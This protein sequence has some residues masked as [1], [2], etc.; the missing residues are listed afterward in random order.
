MPQ[1]GFAGIFIILGLV[2]VVLVAV[3][4]GKNWFN[5]NSHSTSGKLDRFV[6]QVGGSECADGPIFTK[7][8]L[9]PAK[10]LSIT[11]LGNLNPPDHTIPT[12][13]IYLVVKNNNEIHPKS[14]TAVFSP[15]DITITR[16]THQSTKKS[17]K[18]FSDDYSIY[19]R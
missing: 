6:S 2:A 1:R 3:F 19:Q 16:I 5:P 9:D 14:A 12:D 15:S 10:I 17:G 11:P 7:I 13:H 8:P 18:A 4:F